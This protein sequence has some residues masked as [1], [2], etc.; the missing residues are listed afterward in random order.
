MTEVGMFEFV[1]ALILGD[2]QLI[3]ALALGLAASIPLL[4]AF[5]GDGI[6]SAMHR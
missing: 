1:K 3:R 2:P 5:V 6:R 4:A